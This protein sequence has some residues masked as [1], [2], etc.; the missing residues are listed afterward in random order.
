LKTVVAATESPK[1]VNLSS[2]LDIVKEDPNAI[3]YISE[4]PEDKARI[5]QQTNVTGSL[6]F[7]SM[8]NAPASLPG[9]LIS[10]FL[11]VMLMIGVSCLYDVKTNDKF[12]TIPLVVGKES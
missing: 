11:I 3:I 5:M 10:L 1:Q 4:T 7:R 2:L 9:V 8:A 6:L 12:G